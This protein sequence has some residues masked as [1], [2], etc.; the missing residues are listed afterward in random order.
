MTTNQIT[1][2]IANHLPANE[3]SGMVISKG[4]VN[5]DEAYHMQREIAQQRGNDTIPDTLMLLEHPHTYTLGSAGHPENILWS[6]AQLEAE[7]V[8]VQRVDRGGD[9]TYH[10]PG[11]LVGYP[12]FKLPS[13]VG[14]LHAD[15][16][17]YLRKLEQAIILALADFGLQG[18]TIPSLTGVW[19]G[20]EAAPAKICAIGVKVTTRRVTYH[21]FALNINTT[22]RYFEGIIPCGL[23]DKAVISMEQALERPIRRAEVEPRVIEAFGHVFGHHWR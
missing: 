20:S 23:R 15:V 18:W 17:S 14:S 1:N 10:G 3:R 8:A 9:V 19:I 12:I 21:G 13:Q 6:Q 16:I 7:Q 22:M 5:Y 11:Q 4:L 2:Q